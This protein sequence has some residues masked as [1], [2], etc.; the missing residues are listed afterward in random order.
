MTPKWTDRTGQPSFQAD[1]R[2]FLGLAAGL[3]TA[4]L[5]AAGCTLPPI[6]RSQSPEET[7]DPTISSIRLV[8]DYAQAVG[9]FPLT[10]EAVAL[11]TGLP[12][13]GSDPPA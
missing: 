7:E 11:V 3:T 1:R 6:F 12:G 9:G 4:G 2:L 8:G 5:T 13:T 10:V